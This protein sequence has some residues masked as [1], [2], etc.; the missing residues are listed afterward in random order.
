MH[1]LDLDIEV[2]GSNDIFSLSYCTYFKPMALF[3]Y[4]PYDSCHPTHTKRGIVLTE[5][6]R[7]WKTNKARHCFERCACFLSQKF[8]ERGYPNH[9]LKSCIDRVR[10]SAEVVLDEATDVENKGNTI[11]VPF[12]M[13]YFD[14]A[15]KIGLSRILC[16]HLDL[17]GLAQGQVGKNTFGWDRNGGNFRFFVSYLSQPNLFRARYAKFL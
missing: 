16:K 10:S 11:L 13:P 8:R 17:L 9:L 6:A 3:Q 14:R 15:E 7:L 12:K 5:L 4:V 2:A 1:F